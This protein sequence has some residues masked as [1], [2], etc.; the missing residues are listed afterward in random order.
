MKFLDVCVRGLADMREGEG[1]ESILW[2]DPVWTVELAL[3][4]IMR[5]GIG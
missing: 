3:R 4:K 2:Q 5:E 1:E